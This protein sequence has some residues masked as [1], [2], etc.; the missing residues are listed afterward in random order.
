MRQFKL[1]QQ[2]A[3]A[4][5]TGRSGAA[6]L[7]DL[8]RGGAGRAGQAIF[9]GGGVGNVPG[10]P[11][12]VLARMQRGAAATA[13]LSAI[14]SRQSTALEQRQGLLFASSFARVFCLPDLRPN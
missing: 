5:G 8:R 6:A 13:A 12:R 2:I 1:S 9:V 11:Q 3:A 10:V 7:E 4:M 14:Q